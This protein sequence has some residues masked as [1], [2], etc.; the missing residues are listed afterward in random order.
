MKERK[1]EESQEDYCADCIFDCN[2]FLMDNETCLDKI[3][4]KQS[5]KWSG[6]KLD[7]ILQI[8]TEHITGVYNPRD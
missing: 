4:M 1:P 8:E 7:E 5:Q 2:V 6:G 3:T